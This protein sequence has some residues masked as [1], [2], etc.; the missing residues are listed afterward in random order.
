VKENTFLEELHLDG[1]I[2]LKFIVKNLVG[3]GG[4]GLSAVSWELLAW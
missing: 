4:L 3:G 1:S 2:V